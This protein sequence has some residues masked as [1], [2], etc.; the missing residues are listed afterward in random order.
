MSIAVAVKHML[1][2]GMTPEAIVAAVAEMEA[3]FTQPETA[4]DR[5]READR[6]RIATKRDK[7][8]HDATSRDNATL[9][10]NATPSSPLV[11]PSLSPT[12]PYSPP[13]NPPTIP[14]ALK[15]ASAKDKIEEQCRE[16]AG[17]E[18]SPSPSL[19][20]L[21][22][23]RRCLAA[24]ASLEMDILPTLRAIKA[25]G[26]DVVSWKYAERPIMDAKA[27]REAPA[28]I[29]QAPNARGQPPPSAKPPSAKRLLLDELARRRN[30]AD[31]PPHRSQ[32][33][34][35]TSNPQRA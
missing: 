11:P 31:E 17:C 34:E 33:I 29:G 8:R 24:G 12:P 30:E 28:V 23:I 14:A 20:D 7:A 22:P 35:L 27:S 25:R 32:L 10:D 26:V 18:N 6:I 5:K 4:Q 16:A 15:G 21:S 13:Y 2:A 1:A 9:R 3:A 19:F